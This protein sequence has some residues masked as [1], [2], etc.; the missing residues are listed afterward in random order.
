MPIAAIALFLMAV[1]VPNM[2]GTGSDPY[3]N[4]L[5]D[6]PDEHEGGQLV[7]LDAHGA[8]VYFEPTDQRAFDLL[9]TEDTYER[10]ED[11]GSGPLEDVVEKIEETVGWDELSPFGEDHS[12]D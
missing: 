8:P 5:K 1:P 10:N 12:N 3:R 4:S 9:H 2:A 7:G 6:Y 11:R